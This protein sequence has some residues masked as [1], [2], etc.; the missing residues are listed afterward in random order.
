MFTGII[1]DQG[2][3]ERIDN[4]QGLLSVEVKTTFATNDLMIGGSVACDGICLS[5]LDSLAIF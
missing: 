2:V 1:S 4:N 3:I 5:A